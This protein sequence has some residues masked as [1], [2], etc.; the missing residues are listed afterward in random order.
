M[1]LKVLNNYTVLNNLVSEL[2]ITKTDGEYYKV[3]IDTNCIDLCMKY[4]WNI[5]NCGK[6]GDY[7]Y[8]SANANNKRVL[9]HRL[10]SGADKHRIVDHINHNTLD[11]RIENLRNVGREENSQNRISAHKT[12][13]SK[14]INIM[15]VTKHKGKTYE[16]DY[17]KVEI[18]FNKKTKRIQRYFEFSEHGKIMAIEFC[19]NKRKELFGDE[20]ILCFRMCD[21]TEISLEGV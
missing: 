16:K 5:I 19:K 1:K 14:I 17:Y 20:A 2:K 4:H 21:N 13:K 9:M 7:K 6:F 3:L 12:S 11:N 8:A 10:L 18:S 15:H